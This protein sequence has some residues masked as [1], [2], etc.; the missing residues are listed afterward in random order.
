MRIL[1]AFADGNIIWAID[2]AVYGLYSINRST[3]ETKCV[4]DSFELFRYGKFT[5]GALVKWKEDYILIIPM[6]V[7]KKWIVYN[8]VNGHISYKN[9]VNIE[10]QCLFIG[11]CE[12][13]NEA[14]FCPVN[15]K[16]PILIVN[17][18]D[19]SSVRTI[20]DWNAGI[21][22]CNDE[23]AYR[24]IYNRKYIFFHYA[25]HKFLHGCPMD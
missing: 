23:V 19:L 7:S 1:F 14:Y 13:T 11:A 10:C 18:D 6:D 4:I 2:E 16:D 15:S 24:G 8:K 21:C 17:F 20:E 9:F 5:P 3:S 12:A 22:G 25:V